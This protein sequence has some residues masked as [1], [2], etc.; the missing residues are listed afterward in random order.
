MSP[1]LPLRHRRIDSMIEWDC[2]GRI[3][4]AHWG[5]HQPGFLG[6][7]TGWFGVMGCPVHEHAYPLAAFPEHCALCWWGRRARRSS[8]QQKQEVRIGGFL[9]PGPFFPPETYTEL[10][11]KHVCS[12]PVDVHTQPARLPG[13]LVGK[14]CGLLVI[15]GNIQPLPLA[16]VIWIPSLC[17]STGVFWGK[18]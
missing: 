18:W 5:K 6:V 11:S 9:L 1:K 16:I 14:W 12:H 17:N 3:P 7:L 13:R 10:N 8:F 2:L 4:S 15:W